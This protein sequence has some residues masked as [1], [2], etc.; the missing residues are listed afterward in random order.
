VEREA[1]PAISGNKIYKNFKEGILLV[2]SSNAVIEK[3]DI[4]KNIECNVALG[5]VNSHHTILAE[6]IISDS[7]GVGVNV[8]YSGH[9]KIVRND[10]C[11]NED[12]LLLIG[13]KPDIENNYI[14]ENKSNGL[15]CEKKSN[16]LIVENFI[17]RNGSAGILLRHES[18]FKESVIHSNLVVSNEIDLGMQEYNQQFIDN[19]TLSNTIEGQVYYPEGISC[20]LI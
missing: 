5:G 16:P 12:G 14:Y 4:S 3:N 8:I 17:T 13:S 18:A 11:R 1:F 19:F 7:P 9:L 2:E 15:A 10:I 20:Q 6:N